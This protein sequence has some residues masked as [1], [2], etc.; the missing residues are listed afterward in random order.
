MNLQEYLR[1]PNGKGSSAIMVNEMRRILDEQYATL[2]GKIS[3]RWYKLSKKYLI[4]HIRVPSKSV[5][6][7]FYDVLLEF[8]IDTIPKNKSVINEG[9]V[10]VFSNCPSFVYTYAN[11]FDKEKNFISWCKKKY[12]KEIFSKDPKK[13]NPMKIVNYERSLYFATRYL[14]SEGRNY[15]GK[16]DLI[17]IKQDSYAQILNKVKSSDEILEI[18]NRHKRIEKPQEKKEKETP[19][20][21][22]VKSRSFFKQKKGVTRKVKTTKQVKSVK[23]TKKI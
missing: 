12:P 16:I 4:A 5:E 23:K 2:R 20:K 13:R 9:S 8:D 15:K 18:Y 10:R 22:E 17:T 21:R 1:N 6:R 19:P 7:L 14:L 11:V 3:I